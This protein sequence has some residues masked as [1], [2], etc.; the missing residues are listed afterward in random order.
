MRR[1]WF[2]N[3]VLSQI[4]DSSIMCKDHYRSTFQ[5]GRSLIMK[6]WKAVHFCTFVFLSDFEKIW[7]YS[8]YHS[9][10]LAVYLFPKLDILPLHITPPFLTEHT[11]RYRVF[12][13]CL[14]PIFVAVVSNFQK[15]WQY[16]WY[17]GWFFPA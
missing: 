7:Q 16:A 6:S 15:I 8:C 14:L 1:K 4:I 2:V 10:F 13:N 17:R 9:W 12:Q 5:F 11:V 3:M